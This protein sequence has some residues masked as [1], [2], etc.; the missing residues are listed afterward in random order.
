[1]HYLENSVGLLLVL[2]L[3][4]WSQEIYLLAFNIYSTSTAVLFYLQLV[5]PVTCPVSKSLTIC[6]FELYD[7]Q[8]MLYK[9]YSRCHVT[10]QQLAV[11]HHELRSSE[12]ADWD[13]KLSVVKL[14]WIHD[15]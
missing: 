10:G 15:E 14:T 9:F 11:L 1:V 13:L 7:C 4:K 8:L 3:N 12:Y 5:L 2:F 6:L